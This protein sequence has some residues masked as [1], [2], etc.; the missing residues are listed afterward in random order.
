MK[1]NSVIIDAKTNI[2]IK[3]LA[4]FFFGVFR[5]PKNGAAAIA[6][7]KGIIIGENVAL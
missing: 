1:K 4:K 3:F 5:Q 7:T 2:M 6:K